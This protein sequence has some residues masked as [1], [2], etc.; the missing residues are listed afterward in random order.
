M[1]HI[2]YEVYYMLQLILIGTFPCRLLLP[3]PINED[4]TGNGAK[5]DAPGGK[6][7]IKTKPFSCHIDVMAMSCAPDLY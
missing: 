5:L 4:E 1:E 3:D 6:H 2:W 7:Q